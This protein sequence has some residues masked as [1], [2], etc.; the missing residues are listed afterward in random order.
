MR[1]F[2][3]DRWKAGI[4]L[5][6]MLL[7]L[8]LMVWV[9]VSVAGAY[10]GAS[11]VP[12]PGT[13][14][15]QATPTEDA[16]VTTLNK[17]VLQH[18][19]DWWW[20]F[21]ATILTSVIST[22]TLA[23]AGLFTVVRYFNDRRDARAKQDEE[24]RRW[25][26]DQ[27]AE[28]EKRAEERFQAVVEGLG[29]ARMEKRIGAA[30]VLRT[31][32]RPGYE[33]FYHQVFDLTA[34]T[35]RLPRVPLSS[36]DSMP[37]PSAR[38]EPLTPLSQAL[39]IVFRESF[40]LARDE[41]KNQLERQRAHFRPQLLSAAEIHLDKAYLVEAHLEETWLR[42]ASLREANLTR[43][44]F[45]AADL[46]RADL[47]KAHFWE[48]D[49]RGAHLKEADLSGTLLRRVDL[50]EAN[51]TEAN[52]GEAT[53][54]KVNLKKANLKRA[55]LAGADL[56][57]ADLSGADLSGVNLNKAN[58]E[59]AWSLRDAKLHGVKGLTPKQRIACKAKGA[60]VDEE[61]TASPSR[62]P[63]SPSPPERS[64]DVQAQWA[65]SAQVNTLP[66]STDGST[67][68]SS[69]ASHDTQAQAAPPAQESMPTSDTDGSIAASSKPDPEA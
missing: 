19:N 7:L 15:V 27:E 28:R 62:S 55:N 46:E 32:L 16:T 12:T 40:P 4:A 35:L 60:I 47:R 26:K 36:D 67:T 43:A 1:S 52:L 9:P 21:G 39:I 64:P 31:F 24:Q 54:R 48:T 17:E 68:P 8:V 33:Q 51:L 6:G 29:D 66:P 11:G 13:A 42:E 56:S 45:M 25:L 59:D 44:C 14:I 50:S 2:K 10:E 41:L 63:I 57:G 49:L 69:K 22:L 34:A 38:P 5:A 53:L 37:P 61:T 20:S 58:I 3:G 30:V 18:E 23:L 65:P